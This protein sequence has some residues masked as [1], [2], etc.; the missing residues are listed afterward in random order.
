MSPTTHRPCPYL[1]SDTY[2]F[3]LN[4]YDIT[5]QN[6]MLCTYNIKSDDGI[7]PKP[8]PKHPQLD[9]VACSEGQYYY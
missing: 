7:E 1:S 8:K 4:A 6:K 3:L 5:N 2:Q 9:N